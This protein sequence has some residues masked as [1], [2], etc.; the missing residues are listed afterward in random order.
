MPTEDDLRAAL[1]AADAP[2]PA[3]D[4]RRVV[5]RARARRAPAQ[6]G[7]ALVGVL[8][9]T[10]IGVVAVQTLPL[11]APP[12]ESAMVAEG[13]AA[14]TDSSVSSLEDAKRAPAERLNLCG[15]PVAEAVP[16]TSGLELTVEFPETATSGTDPIDGVVRLTNTSG[17]R[18]TGTTAAVP[19]ITMARD[20]VT[21]WHSNG[22]MILSLTIVDLAPGESLEYRT[23]IVP[24]ECGPEDEAETFR[25]DLPALAPGDYTLSAAIDFSPD[26]PPA[27]APALADLVMG[28]AS[29]IRLD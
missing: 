25:E 8:A 16:S 4:A 12:V 28:P 10:G 7:G 23:S 19:A 26:A 18:V 2:E 9:L 5:A 11:T 17:E 21:V 27:D 24:V 13:G 20:G 22:P 14:D 6:V 15:A 1:R 29:S 3:L